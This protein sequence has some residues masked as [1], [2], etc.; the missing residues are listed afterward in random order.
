MVYL[1]FIFLFGLLWFIVWC[2]A[3]SEYG[4][5]VVFKCV[6]FENGGDV[7][8]RIVENVWYLFGRVKLGGSGI[9]LWII[10]WK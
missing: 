3:D 8:R 4:G 2:A 6:L 9:C 1:L 5:F 7:W 10:W